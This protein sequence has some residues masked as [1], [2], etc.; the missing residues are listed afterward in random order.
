[1]ASGSL[2][3]FISPFSGAPNT[4]GVGVE[5]TELSSRGN[6]DDRQVPY[7]VLEYNVFS[8]RNASRGIEHECYN[9][10]SSLIFCCSSK[11]FV[12]RANDLQ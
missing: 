9:K 4:F 3:V 8:T 2:M 6:R 11:R 5:I 10:A 7:I 1:M 12:P